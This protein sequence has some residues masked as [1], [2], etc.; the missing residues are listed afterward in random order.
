MT[1]SGLADLDGY[2]S[3]IWW[4]S[5]SFSSYFPQSFCMLFCSHFQLSCLDRFVPA[6]TPV[7]PCA[8]STTGSKHLGTATNIKSIPWKCISIKKYWN[9]LMKIHLNEND[10]NE[11]DMW[12]WLTILILLQCQM[13]MG[14]NVYRIC[15]DCISFVNPVQG[16]TYQF[17]V[18]QFWR[19]LYSCIV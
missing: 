9:H 18:H 14:Y 19:D 2:R 4:S 7:P 15:T 12:L 16:I 1:G 17:G 8:C 13:P 3:T 10:N 5:W 11:N 6:R